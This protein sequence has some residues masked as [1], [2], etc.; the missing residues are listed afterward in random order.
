MIIDDLNTTIIFRVQNMNDDSS[1]DLNIDDDNTTIIISSW[2]NI[3]DNNIDDDNT[4]LIYSWMGLFSIMYTTVN[5]FQNIYCFIFEIRN[6]ENM[7]QN[8]GTELTT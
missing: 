7:F 4:T 8:H 1:D 5:T 2:I 6:I 3:D